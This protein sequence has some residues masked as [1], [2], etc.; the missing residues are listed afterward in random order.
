MKALAQRADALKMLSLRP[1]GGLYNNLVIFYQVILSKIG[2]SW[3]KLGFQLPKNM[4]LEP[5]W[6]HFS[7]SEHIS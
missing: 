5:I 3:L 1:I 4:V 2:G 7:Y 6:K